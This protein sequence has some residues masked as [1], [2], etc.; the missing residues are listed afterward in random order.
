MRLSKTSMTLLIQSEEG[1]TSVMEQ[2]LVGF[3]GT[4][5]VITSIST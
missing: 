4:M 2:D 3:C 5:P 1:L